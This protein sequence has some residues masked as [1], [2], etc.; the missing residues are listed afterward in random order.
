MSE[1]GGAAALEDGTLLDLA[2][3]ERTR[4]VLELGGH[5]ED[6]ASKAQ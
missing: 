4:W 2:M 3:V 5:R 6:E 1:S